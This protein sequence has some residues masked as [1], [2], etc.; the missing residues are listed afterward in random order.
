MGEL[1][2]Y[3]DGHASDV[4]ETIPIILLAANSLAGTLCTTAGADRCDWRTAGTNLRANG[5]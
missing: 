1:G 5:H 2:V 3:V 4:D